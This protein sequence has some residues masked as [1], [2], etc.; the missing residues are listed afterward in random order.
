MKMKRSV[1]VRTLALG[2]ASLLLLSTI[3]YAA[4]TGS[5]YVVLK[6]AVLDA[7]TVRNATGQISMTT[8]LNGV[9]KESEKTLAVYDG[10][11]NYL[12]YN[13][14]S[15][16]TNTFDFDGYNS[17]TYSANGLQIYPCYFENSEAKWY[18][19]YTHDPDE[20]YYTTG[21]FAT[22]TE[23]DRDSARMRF[24]E[25]LVDALVGNLKNNITMTTDG[26]VRHITGTLTE[27]QLPELAKAGL[28]MLAEQSANYTSYVY[29]ADSLRFDGDTVTW[30][31]TYINRSEKTVTVYS[32]PIHWA[33][34]EE[35]QKL[36][37]GEYYNKDGTDYL[38]YWG[39]NETEDGRVYVYT[40]DR[41][42]VSENTTPVTAADFADRD[43]LE[44]PLEKITLNSVSADA[45]VD[46]DGNLT[47]AKLNAS[48]TTTDI[49]G[50]IS[51]IEFAMDA[52]FTNI[53]T[54]T[55]VCPIAGAQALL[56]EDYMTEHF[57]TK[58]CGVYFNLLPDGSINPDSVTTT[59][60][61]ET[62]LGGV[63]G[64]YPYPLV[65][66]KVDASSPIAVTVGIEY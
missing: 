63:S 15:A 64:T 65:T 2:V 20:I 10:D 45:Y 51:E 42:V 7:L 58:Y 35:T 18:Y 49:F 25:L 52:S 31:E 22:F 8:T 59:Y 5:A 53:G 19:A 60:P 40:A 39:W 46:E 54:S 50:E 6:D 21:V 27:A 36:Y 9:V 24:V 41:E 56:T 12:T 16:N 62:E 1:L 47:S 3:A 29:E 66:D 32:Q 38:G 44:R 43:P 23:A 26:D 33:T 11:G 61:G 17:F 30:S 28:D 4:V 13:Y 55:P 14:N 34:E 48:I 57:G 37:S